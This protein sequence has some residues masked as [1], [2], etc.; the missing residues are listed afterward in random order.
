[1]T[2]LRFVAAEGEREE[3]FAAAALQVDFAGQRDRAMVGAIVNACQAPVFFQ[4]AQPIRCPNKADGSPQPG[5]GCRQRAD[6]VFLL[7]AQQRHAFEFSQVR[8]VI[9]AAVAQVR[10]QM[11]VQ[12]IIF[13]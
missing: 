5:G 12:V 3:K 7:P 9:F 11:R 13:Q 8:A 6:G 10:L 4:I 2:R 1:M